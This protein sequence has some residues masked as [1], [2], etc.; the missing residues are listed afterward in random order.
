MAREIYQGSIVITGNGSEVIIDPEPYP[1]NAMASKIISEHPP[2]LGYPGTLPYAAIQVVMPSKWGAKKI[3]EALVRGGRYKQG[4]PALK[5][6][7]IDGQGKGRRS[8]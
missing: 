2:V 7:M 3:V 6:T 4:D 8:I 5:K 1:R